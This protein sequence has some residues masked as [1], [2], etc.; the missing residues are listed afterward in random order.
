MKNASQ[1]FAGA[2]FAL[3]FA[4]LI[5]GS[6]MLSLVENGLAV[7]G[8][9][10]TT[11]TTPVYEFL[12]ENSQIPPNPNNTQPGI[13]EVAIPTEIVATPTSA[14]PPL[15]G[16]VTYEVQVGDTLAAL[17]KI[18]GIGEVELREGN[19]LFVSDP[20]LLPGMILNIP[21]IAIAS[22]VASPTDTTVPVVT[23]AAS[24]T[25][26]IR[27]IP[28]AGW[29]TY[30]VRSGDT[31]FSLSLSVGSNV[32]A[33]QS[34]NCMGSTTLIRTGDRILLPRYPVNP[35]LPTVTRPPIIPPSLPPPPSPV[36]P[37]TATPVLPP[38]VTQV[39]PPTAT[40]TSVPPPTNTLVPE[41]TNTEAPPPPP[42]P[43]ADASETP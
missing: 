14:C 5:A 23:Q 3:L 27:C 38:T 39:L 17:A 15:S 31:L 16:W 42:P 37:N 12:P 28:P 1:V 13:A 35:P 33:L 2:L 8:A 32:S 41:P 24:T 36:P 25:T 26:P 34:A 40:N 19:C 18:H 4:G 10:R 30:I 7:A 21:Q 6:L 9:P 29:V 43:T 22:V 11:E 20:I